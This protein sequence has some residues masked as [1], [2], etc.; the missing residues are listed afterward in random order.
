MKQRFLPFVALAAALLAPSFAQAASEPDAPALP[1]ADTPHPWYRPR[2]L[3]LQ[4]AGG[5]GMVSAGAGYTYAQDKIDTDILLG[6]VPKKFAGSTLTLASA[7][8]IYSPFTVRISDKWQVKPVSVGAYFSYT[9][10]TLNDEE[11]GQYTKDYYWWSSDTRY[12]PLAGGRVT[13]ARPAK[14]NGR[15][16]TVSVYYDLSTNDLYLQSYVTNTKGL[17]LGQI[18][19]LGLGVKADF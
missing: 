5:L 12:G 7:K 9:H 1:A 17:S 8:F 11:R 19:V 6:Y 14:A 10:G 2:H 15:P 3:V 4:T 13:Y 16:R 18:L